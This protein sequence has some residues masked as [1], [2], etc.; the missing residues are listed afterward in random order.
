M[1]NSFPQEPVE[2]RVVRIASSFFRHHDPD[3]DR[4]RC[5]LPVGDD[6]GRRRIIRIDRLDEGEAA[7]MSPL[8]FHGIARVGA[9]HMEKAEMKIAPPTPSVSMAATISSPV[10]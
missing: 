5:L 4:A 10:T 6:I 3:A 1:A 7:G 9:V 8:H 2:A